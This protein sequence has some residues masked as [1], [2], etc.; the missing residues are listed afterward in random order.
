MPH[1]GDARVILLLE[2]RAVHLCAALQIRQLRLSVHT[3]GAEFVD[4]ELLAVNAA[5][6]LRKNRRAFRV[7]NDNRERYNQHQRRKHN[8]RQQ[9][10]KH[11]LHSLQRPID[12]FFLAHLFTIEPNLLANGRRR[13]LYRCLR[14]RRHPPSINCCCF[15]GRQIF[16]LSSVRRIVRKNHLNHLAYFTTHVSA[17]QLPSRKIRTV[18]IFPAF[19][20]FLP[21]MQE[22]LLILSYNKERA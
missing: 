10:E 5:A 22:N 6:H 4:A 7:I 14:H 17:C 1:T 2:N 12:R 15:C 19:L 20:L 13:L 11:I 18:C 9:G 3:H 21:K 16:T 8:Q